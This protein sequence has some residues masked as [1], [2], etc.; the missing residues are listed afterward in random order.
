QLVLADPRTDFRVVRQAALETVQLA[1]GVDDIFLA[2]FIDA[3][4]LAQVED[5]VALG[6]K[7]D[8]LVMA[9]QEARVPLPRRHRLRLAVAPRRDH[10]DEA[11]QIGRVG[12][13]AVD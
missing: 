11:R 2:P 3:L 9:R 5:G 7:L 6:A 10:D 13:E 1:D 4:R 8:A 12:A